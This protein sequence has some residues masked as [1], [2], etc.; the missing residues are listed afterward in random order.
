MCNCRYGTDFPHTYNEKSLIADILTKVLEKCFMSS[1]L[2]NIK[3][4]FKQLDWI[5]C[6]GN[7]KRKKYKYMKKI[8][9]KAIRTIKLIH[10]ICR[11]KNG[12]LHCQIATVLSMLWQFKSFHRRIMGKVQVGH[13][14]L[15]HCRHIYK[16]FTEMFLE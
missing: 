6:H 7:K 15:S 11:P 3:I 12:V 13:F 1:P 10:N 16:S 14:F 9:S 4:L 8:S 5:G 2:L